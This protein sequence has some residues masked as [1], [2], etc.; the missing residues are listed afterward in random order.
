MVISACLCLC[1]LLIAAMPAFASS[2]R[3]TFTSFRYIGEFVHE[4]T[5]EF[6]GGKGIFNVQGRGTAEGRH[7]VRSREEDGDTRTNINFRL[8]GTTDPNNALDLERME[9][10]AL[11]HLEAERARAIAGLDNQLKSTNVMNPEMY[12]EEMFRINSYYDSMIAQVKLGYMDAKKNVRLQSAIGAL[13]DGIKV[14]LSMGVEM[15]PG[16]SGYIEQR[17]VTDKTKKGEYFRY[18]NHMGNTG[19]TTEKEVEFKV[20]W[21]GND[22][23]TNLMTERLRVE[24]FAEISEFTEITIGKPRDGSW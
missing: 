9:R 11:A 21:P 17:I 5:F 12:Q 19:G 16:Q 22:E 10:A 13:N 15:K 14:S 3:Y 24:G 23:P 6:F 2:Y 20:D 8:A 7:E 18:T 1:I 4:K